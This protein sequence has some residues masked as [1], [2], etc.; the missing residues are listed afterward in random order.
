M[1]GFARLRPLCCNGT[2]TGAGGRLKQTTYGNGDSVSYT[3]DE[4]D[5][6]T[7]KVYTGGR[8]VT[9]TYNADGQIAE[10]PVLLSVN[11]HLLRL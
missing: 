8:Y 1:H 11:E 5:R 10:R 9:Y 3:Y 6:L 7:G 2:Q 4:L